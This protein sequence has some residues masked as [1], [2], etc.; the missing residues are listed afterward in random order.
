GAC[1]YESFASTLNHGGVATASS[2]IYK[3]GVGCGAC[4]QI[5]CTNQAI[6]RK[7]GLKVVVT[8]HTEN[9]QTD[10]VVSVRT[11][12]SLAQPSKSAE[13]VKMGIANVEYKRIPCEYPG[14]NMTLKIDKSSSYPYFLA[15]QFLYQGG[16]TD[17]TSVDVAQ[18][19][20]SNWKYMTR[21]H[22]AV[23]SIEKPPMGDLSVRWLVTSGYDGYWVW[24]KRSVLPSNWKVGSVYDSGIQI[25]EIA[26]EGCSP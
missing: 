22:G 17:I 19:G 16:Q 6:C 8:D 25:K 2:Q 5:R 11:F 14:Q 15:V 10:F 1:G 23:W 9:N 3:E 18:V 20:T 13:L 24:S 26:Q 7:S 4:Y 21:N 12:S